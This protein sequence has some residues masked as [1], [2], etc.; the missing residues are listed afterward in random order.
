ML[1]PFTHFF[2]VAVLILGFMSVF[3]DTHKKINV[4]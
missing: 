1:I 3:D 4:F 2:N